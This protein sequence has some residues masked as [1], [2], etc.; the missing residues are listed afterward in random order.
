MKLSH[1]QLFATPRTV[2]HQAPL[3]MEFSRQEY[4][5][6]L[7]FP[8]NQVIKPTI[9]SSGQPGIPSLLTDITGHAEPQLLFRLPKGD[10]GF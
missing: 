1:I 3:S 7:L 5:S 4:W 8:F 10:L 2:A 6:E 9:I